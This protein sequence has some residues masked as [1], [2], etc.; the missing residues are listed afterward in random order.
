[1]KP[2]KTSN[3]SSAWTLAIVPVSFP[4]TGPRRPAGACWLHRS[5]RR[6]SRFMQ[7]DH[8]PRSSRP[9][10]PFAPLP[11]LRE[12]PGV[13]LRALR[14]R[15]LEGGDGGTQLAG[16]LVEIGHLLRRFAGAGVGLRRGV[17]D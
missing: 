12:G 6:S 15:Q 11:L 8:P 13:R 17:R 5:L 10:F 3:W 14:L 4:S 9:P 16:N 1:M 2:P 7:E